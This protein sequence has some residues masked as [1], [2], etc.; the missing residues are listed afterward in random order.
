MTT[1]VTDAHI[2]FRCYTP[3]LEVRS[4]GDGRTVFGIA[5][6]YNVPMQIDDNLI[7]EFIPGAFN[8]QLRAANRVMYSREH[9]E[10]GGVQIG[11]LTEMR[12][13]AVGLYVEMRAARTP[14]GDETLEL[15]REGIL[16]DLSVAFW[17]GKNELRASS[18]GQVTRRVSARL[19]EVAS[20]GKGAYGQFATAHGLRARGG[21]AGGSAI[22]QQRSYA[23]RRIE[24]TP[25]LDSARA[26]L[27]ALPPLLPPPAQSR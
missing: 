1:A 16:P 23:G 26:V 18:Q 7:E 2:E 5:V 20:V 19:D 15:I 6:P 4:T 3:E 12:D 13:D 25:N 17:P 9:V 11:R 27:A 14:I 8:A 22:P 24:T 21:A 10:L